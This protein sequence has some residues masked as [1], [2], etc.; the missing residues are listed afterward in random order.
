MLAA[1]RAASAFA[2]ARPLADAELAALRG[3]F[4]TADGL[5]IS[6]GYRVE[7]AVEDGLQLTARFN[8]VAR[9]DQP[10]LG[11]S[12]GGGEG[13]LAGLELAGN[14][15]VQVLAGTP[16]VHRAPMAPATVS[17]TT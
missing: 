3:G 6:F 9:A 12:L 7:L 4:H 11:V 1:E 8:P 15:A 10:A 13:P 14:G 17:A 2:D 5:E 16:K